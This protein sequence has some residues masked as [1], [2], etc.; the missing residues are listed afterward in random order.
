MPSPWPKNKE[1]HERELAWLSPKVA[2]AEDRAVEID[3]SLGQLNLELSLMGCSQKKASEEIRDLKVKREFLLGL[4]FLG[5]I[6]RL[7]ASALC[8]ESSPP[9]PPFEAGTV[10]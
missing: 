9:S 2:A 8:H 1:Q 10:G 7:G 6:L 3:S 5:G 4:V